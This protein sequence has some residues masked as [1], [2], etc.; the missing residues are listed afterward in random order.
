M[1]ALSKIFTVRAR[2]CKRCGGLLTSREAVL[3][4]YGHTCKRKMQEQAQ[5]SKPHPDQ[6]TPFYFESEEK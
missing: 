2:R 4:G 1:D 6:M 3:E 5:R